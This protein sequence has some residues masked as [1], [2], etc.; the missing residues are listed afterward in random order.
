MIPPLGLD[1]P[2]KVQEPGLPASTRCPAGEGE[3][4]RNRRVPSPIPESEKP[5]TVETNPSPP[6]KNKEGDRDPDTVPREAGTIRPKQ[7][8]QRLAGH[9]A[10][11]S[12]R[13]REGSCGQV[14]SHTAMGNHGNSGTPRSGETGR[15]PARGAETTEA[16]RKR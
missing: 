14:L 4:S 11:R 7:G 16:G 8:E 2:S 1:L 9:R 13:N 15:H 5:V 3:G 10:R 12:G 6:N